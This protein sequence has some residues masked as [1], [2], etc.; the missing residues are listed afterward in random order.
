MQCSSDAA[1]LKR[2]LDIHNPLFGYVYLLDPK[3]RIRWQ[4]AGAATEAEVQTMLGLAKRLA[5]K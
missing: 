2:E 4:A 1:A 5:S 3:A